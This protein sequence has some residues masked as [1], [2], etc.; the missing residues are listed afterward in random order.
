MDIHLDSCEQV[1]K[2]T[3][4][5]IKLRKIELNNLKVHHYDV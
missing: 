4:S 1:L 5:T 3:I 2:V